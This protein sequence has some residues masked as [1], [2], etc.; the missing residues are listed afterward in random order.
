LL[1]DTAVATVERLVPRKQ[2]MLFIA[3]NCTCEQLN[4]GKSEFFLYE[5]RM[6]Y[7]SAV[8]SS[9]RDPKH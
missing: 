8:T 3:E 4:N 7:N 9:L 2:G 5:T 6:L 1:D